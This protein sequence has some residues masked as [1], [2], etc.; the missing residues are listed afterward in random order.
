VPPRAWSN[1]PGDRSLPN[2]AEA[3]AIAA[4]LRADGFEPVPRSAAQAAANASALRLLIAD[5]SIADC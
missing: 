3:A 5:V 4:W 2:A 1:I